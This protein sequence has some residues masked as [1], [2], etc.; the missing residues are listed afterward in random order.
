[1]HERVV[2]KENSRI[3]P[4]HAF[5]ANKRKTDLLSIKVIGKSQSGTCFVEALASYF[6]QML[7]NNYTVGE[8]GCSIILQ[9][10]T[11]PDGRVPL[12]PWSVRSG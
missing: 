4:G 2:R 9:G 11:K 3:N 8:A 10:C 12:G 5:T 7:A 1:M 6:L